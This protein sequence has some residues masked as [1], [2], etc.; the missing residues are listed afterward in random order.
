MPFPLA[1]DYIQLV[2]SALG[3]SLPSSY[4]RAMRLSNGGEIVADDD[5]WN[6]YPI[7]DTSDKKRL[8]RT[9][10]HILAETQKLREWPSF[11]REAIAI[12]GNG[13]GDQLV[14]MKVEEAYDDAIYAWSHETGELKEVASDFSQF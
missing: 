7:K 11:P 1:S 2:E 10:N 12:A 14:F 8:A 5:V 6:Q 3:A 13:S 9:C 4:K